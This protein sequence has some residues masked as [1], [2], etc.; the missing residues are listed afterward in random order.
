MIHQGHRFGTLPVL[1]IDVVEWGV[2]VAKCADEM[3]DAVGQTSL[4][5]A[6]DQAESLV[7]LQCDSAAGQFLGMSGQ[8]G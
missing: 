8:V 3:L 4:N 5:G 7:P 6:D 1:P 2:L